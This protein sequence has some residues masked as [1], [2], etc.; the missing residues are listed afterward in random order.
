MG[1]L[2]G[3]HECVVRARI[4]HVADVAGGLGHGQ[5]LLQQPAW[6]GFGF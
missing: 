6:R 3:L 5:Q 1:L 2:G 4:K